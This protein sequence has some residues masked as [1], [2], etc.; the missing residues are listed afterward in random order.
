MLGLAGV[1]SLIQLIGFLFLPE[2]PRWLIAHGHLDKAKRVLMKTCGMERYEEQFY[3]IYDDVETTKRIQRE[4]AGKI[5]P[6]YQHSFPLLHYNKK[7]L[8]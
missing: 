8:K 6:P 3:E 5:V 4:H 7:C 2:S 1:P